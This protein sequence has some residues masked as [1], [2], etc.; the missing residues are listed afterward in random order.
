M[1]EYIVDTNVYVM[2]ANDGAFRTRFEAFVRDHGPLVV[3]AVAVAEVLIGVP[4]SSRH[5]AV[6]R[7]LGAGTEIVA[8]IT[9]DWIMAGAAVAR[10]GGEVVTKGRSFWNDA[11]L[12]AQSARLGAT[13]VTQNAADFRRLRR[14]TGVHAVAPFPM[15]LR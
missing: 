14:Y 2:A 3:S 12:A 7:A 4:D 9:D 1:P 13:L 15:P 8:P 10:L 5:V 6:T 11:L